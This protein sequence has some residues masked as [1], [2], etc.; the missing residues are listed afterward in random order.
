MEYYNNMFTKW[1]YVYIHD[2][3][4]IGDGTTIGSL[5]HI[6]YNVVIGED[7]K[8][9]GCVYIPPLTIIGFNVFIG[10]GVV[11]TNEKYILSGK[12]EG[13]IIQ[14]DVNIGANATIIAGVTLGKGSV[15]GAGSVV[16][17]DV[18]PYSC[19]RGN[20]AREY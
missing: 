2:S 14:D 4:K 18:L 19:V 8:I 20:P 5:S 11:I 15:I 7:C 6:D 13:V 16:T 3:A 1:N 17:K 12:L 10:P 9:Q